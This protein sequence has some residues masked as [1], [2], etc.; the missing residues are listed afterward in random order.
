M[1]GKNT[2]S[3]LL[4]QTVHTTGSD[5]S[6]CK[7]PVLR[8]PP[9]VAPQQ[10]LPHCANGGPNFGCLPA[11][12]LNCLSKWL[13]RHKTTRVYMLPTN[14][15]SFH[16]PMEEDSELR[17][18][19]LDSI[20]PHKCGQVCSDQISQ[21]IKTGVT[22][23]NRRIQLGQPEESAAAGHRSKHN[24]YIHLHSSTWKTTSMDRVIELQLQP[25]TWTERI[26]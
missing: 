1:E 9:W 5:I 18:L 7:A 16:H 11:I 13:A 4:C 10:S 14:I 12:Y 22:E 15:S 24:H 26:V 3:H 21:S 25:N 20:C 23:H 17:C 6:C 8:A 19:G 2:W